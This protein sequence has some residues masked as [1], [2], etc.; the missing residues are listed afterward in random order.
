MAYR[1]GTYVAFDGN[2]TTNPIEGDIK[3]FNLLNAWSE[4][5]NIE[6]NFSDSHQKTYQVND[7][8]KMITLKNRL[9]ERLR[10]SKNMIIF[11]TK[12]TSY[13][14]GLL[15]WEIE[16]AVDDYKLPLII[17]YTEYSRILDVD[18]L[19][20]KWPKA[21]KERIDNRT[22]KCIHLAFKKELV[23]DAISQ[24]SINDKYPNTSKDYYG[25]DTYDS[26]K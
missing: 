22:A 14:R 19:S 4:N 25:K 23:L 10:N 12:N 9:Q 1:N 7:T 26:L 2:G 13:N 16:K 18:S 21:L 8:S 6:F 20:N 11:I 3:Y 5:K 15:C 17:V 24:F